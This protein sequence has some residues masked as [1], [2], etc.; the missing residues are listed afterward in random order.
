MIPSPYFGG[1]KLIIC[2][3]GYKHGMISLNNIFES[4]I[5]LASHNAIIKGIKCFGIIYCYR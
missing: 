3:T 4:I 2:I 1:K 5:K